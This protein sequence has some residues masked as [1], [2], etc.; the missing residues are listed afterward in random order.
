MKEKTFEERAIELV[1]AARKFEKDFEVELEK[2]D[3]SSAAE[4]ATA[5]LE[6]VLKSIRYMPD[7]DGDTL[8][9]HQAMEG[10]AARFV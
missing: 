4:E 8:E 9:Q 2:A 7:D 1:E 10:R 5:H 6:C 3:A